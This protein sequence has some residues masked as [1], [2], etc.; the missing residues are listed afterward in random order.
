MFYY[1][2]LCSIMLYYVLLCYIMFYYVLL[3]S[4][5]LYYVLLCSIVFYYVLLCSIQMIDQNR[6]YV[7]NN[8]IFTCHESNI[9]LSGRS[10]G[11]PFGNIVRFSLEP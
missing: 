7:S 4:I 6:Q 9:N 5:M 2:L 3:C 10:R 11:A 1:V 8:L